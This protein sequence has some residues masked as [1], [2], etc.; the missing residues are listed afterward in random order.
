MINPIND[1]QSNKKNI[2]LLLATVFSLSISTNLFAFL[3]TGFFI[4]NI[5]QF[6]AA[7][8][9][10]S[11]GLYFLK[12]IYFS[13]P[14]YT[15]RING[16]YCYRQNNKEIE[17]VGIAGYKFNDSFHQ[18]LNSFLNEN[19]AYKKIF[20]DSEITTKYDNSCFNPSSRDGNSILRS[21]LEVVILN[22]LELHL[23]SYYI[24][25]ESKDFKIVK[26]TR[27]T[28]DPAILNNRVLDSITKDMEE[29]E[30]FINKTG[31]KLS[32]NSSIVY[33]ISSDGIVYNR[34]SIELP[35]DTTIIRNKQGFIEIENKLFKLKIVPIVN[36]TS[37]Y[38]HPILFKNSEFNP[39]N[40][41]NYSV[42][43]NLEVQVKR[44]FLVNKKAVQLYEW[45]DSFLKKIE[46]YISINRLEERMN[47]EA[48]DLIINNTGLRKI[49]N[50][51]VTITKPQKNTNQDF[52][53]VKT[54]NAS[55]IIRRVPVKDVKTLS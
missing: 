51:Q 17:K 13:H 47:V 15:I 14:K 12:T 40:C 48:L 34:L 11:L 39:L 33:S 10:L 7:I 18:Y 5:Y 55:P 52:A 38:V 6:F 25:H 26:I 23:N 32:K 8:L 50:S 29:R 27:D 53:I 28:L 43:V 46:D 36:G 19:K 4:K 37:L 9:F 41:K 24:E 21:T 3:L 30:A 35:S 16:G 44:C 49:I 45:L 54:A 31:P 20:L 2:L 1:M 22:Q 42:T